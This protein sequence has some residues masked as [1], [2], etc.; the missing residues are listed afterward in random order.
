[1]GDS[2]VIALYRQGKE[3]EAKEEALQL[4]KDFSLVAKDF[5]RISYNLECLFS[6]IYDI[7]IFTDSHNHYLINFVSYLCKQFKVMVY[8]PYKEVEKDNLPTANPRL[9]PMSSLVFDNYNF[10]IG[11]A[12][13]KGNFVLWST[14]C[15]KL[16]YMP[17]DNIEEISLRNISHLQGLVFRN[18]KQKDNFSNKYSNIRLPY[19]IIE[20][21]LPL[22]E[23]KSESKTG[24]ISKDV[25][26]L[27]NNKEVVSFFSN[28][29]DIV[30]HTLSFSSDNVKQH[31]LNS[32][33]DLLNMLDR[34]H[35]I[36]IDEGDIYALSCAAR[37]GLR[38]VT[39]NKD[40]NV[41]KVL[42][43]FKQGGKTERFLTCED[44]WKIIHGLIK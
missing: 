11:L 39:F 40:I 13:T 31:K 41:D 12:W 27:G 4:V 7:V 24:Y 14:V 19:V 30:L 20:H 33:E 34:C 8:G 29:K 37:S 32:D 22:R 3:K 17:Q 21:G 10:P 44:E 5:E 36:I 9:R 6:P 15:N 2:K 38:V 35:T 28:I 26:Y 42:D 25:A 16:I 23:N 18:K 43:S 1:M